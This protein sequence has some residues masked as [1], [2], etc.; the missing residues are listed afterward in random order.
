MRERKFY[1][2]EGKVER[3]CHS[4]PVAHA[5]AAHT[6]P[7]WRAH[8]QKRSAGFS[9]SVFLLFFSPSFLPPRPA[10]VR[11]SSFLRRAAVP[12]L[13]DP[14]NFRTTGATPL[15]LHRFHSPLQQL[16]F[17]PFCLLV[18][19]FNGSSR[20]TA[21]VMQARAKLRLLGRR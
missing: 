4:A 1:A 16:F 13:Y 3:H 20:R 5:T 7:S 9:K 19:T 21:S 18:V 11:G 12:P 17:L 2:G 15:F 6:D 14:E 10:P 8:T